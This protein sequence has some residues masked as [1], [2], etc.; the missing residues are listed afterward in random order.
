MYE[1]IR[2]L[3]HVPVV[4]GRLMLGIALVGGAA[5]LVAFLVLSGARSLNERGARAHVLSD[6]LDRL[7]AVWVPASTARI[8]AVGR[9]HRLRSFGR[10]LAGDLGRHP[11][12]SI[13]NL[14]RDIMSAQHD[15][16]LSYRRLVQRGICSGDGVVNSSRCT[17]DAASTATA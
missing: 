1:A 15:V 9:E 6:L 10:S 13:G 7:L 8:Q 4:N 12:P 2:R 5:N 16:A 11:D 17:C 3:L 14:D